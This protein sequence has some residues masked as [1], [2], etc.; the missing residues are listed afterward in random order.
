M[1]DRLSPAKLRDL[2]GQEL[3][4]SEWFV[5]TQ[6]RIDVFADC[7]EDRQWIHVDR[8]RAAQGPFKSTVAHGFLV[9]SLLPHWLALLPLFQT[10]F[11]AVVNYGLDRVRFVNSVKP[12]DRIRGRA[13][14]RAVE[15]KGLSRLLAKIECTVEIEGSEKPALV[16]ESLALFFL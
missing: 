1:S 10:K 15:R 5:M 11:R 7:T 2:V 12:G 9:L 14:L 3:G 16:S 13:V 4:V 6:D 8:E